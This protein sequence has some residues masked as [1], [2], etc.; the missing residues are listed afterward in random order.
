MPLQYKNNIFGYSKPLSVEIMQNGWRPAEC[1]LHYPK[2]GRRCR[3]KGQ[4]SAVFPWLFKNR[5][6]A[7]AQCFS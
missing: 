4:D 1:E 6:A 5:I 7:A 3:F 2:A